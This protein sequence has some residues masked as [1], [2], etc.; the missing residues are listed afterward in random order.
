MSVTI[1]NLVTSGMFSLDGGTWDVD[2]N[3]WIVG[4][5]EECANGS[6]PPRGNSGA[7]R[8]RWQHRD[9]GGAGDAGQCQ[10]MKGIPKNGRQP[11]PSPTLASPRRGPRDSPR[12][13][14]V[15]AVAR[16]SP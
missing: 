16:R 9:W 6:S 14:G 13:K 2:N 15:P 12:P 10:P 4:N 11:A 1:A 3:V 8:P 5:D 7:H